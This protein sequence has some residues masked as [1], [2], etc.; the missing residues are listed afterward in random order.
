[1]ISNEVYP[2]WTYDPNPLL[3]YVSLEMSYFRSWPESLGM[4]ARSRGTGKKLLPEVASLV[5]EEKEDS[6]EPQGGS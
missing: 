4:A 6:N 5:L 2:Q 3:S 1:M